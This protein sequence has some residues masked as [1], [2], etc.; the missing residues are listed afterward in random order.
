MPTTHPSPRPVRSIV[1]PA[2]APR[3]PAGVAMPRWTAHEP[4]RA[5]LACGAHTYD[6]A[7][8]RNCGGRTLPLAEAETHAA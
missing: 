8:C 5:C 4:R 3:K 2:A 1:R 6:A 7:T